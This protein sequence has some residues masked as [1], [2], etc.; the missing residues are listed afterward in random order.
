[1][2]STAPTYEGVLNKVG[3]NL[4]LSRTTA[5]SIKGRCYPSEALPPDSECGHRKLV[6]PEA[7]LD[8]HLVPQRIQLATTSQDR[9]GENIGFE[10]IALC[11]EYFDET[12]G[13]P[14]PEF[15]YSYRSL[16]VLV[17]APTCFFFSGF[18]NIVVVQNRFDPRFLWCLELYLYNF[19]GIEDFVVHT[20]LRSVVCAFGNHG[21][22]P[23]NGF[24]RK[25]WPGA[26]FQTLVRNIFRAVSDIPIFT[27]H[28]LIDHSYFM[29][30]FL[31]MP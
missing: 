26:T 8:S 15:V 30:G 22:R 25:V 7:P 10:V 9:E 21:L 27:F 31:S 24:C 28:D 29:I 3:R 16:E 2:F 11:K 17:S 20:T 12:L 23:A 19:F 18:G 5:L 13:L 6:D 4:P 1:M 14:K